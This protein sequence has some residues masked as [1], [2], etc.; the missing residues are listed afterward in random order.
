MTDHTIQA[1]R[2]VPQE[3]LSLPTPADLDPIAN[4]I[5]MRFALAGVSSSK[6]FQV[7]E[8]LHYHCLQMEGYPPRLAFQLSKLNSWL[9]KSRRDFKDD[10][11]LEVL[12]V[13]LNWY[14]QTAQQHSDP[15]ARLRIKH[16]LSDF[17]AVM[18]WKYKS[19]EVDRH[20]DRRDRRYWRCFDRP[21]VLGLESGDQEVK[22]YSLGRGNYTT[23][24]LK[25]KSAQS[26]QGCYR[27]LQSVNKI[28][29]QMR[30]LDQAAD[31]R[32]QLDDA[33]EDLDIGWR[34]RL[35]VGIPIVEPL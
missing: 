13:V 6:V 7:L 16:S 3:A 34:A 23:I 11:A 27:A 22:L 18:T 33:I 30:G 12:Q 1:S 31:L 20:P 29:V 17:M 19:F 26:L 4:F 9:D 15:P 8:V 5:A 21:M 2:Q 35:A 32:R 25:A 10:E 28:I 14:D 24:Q